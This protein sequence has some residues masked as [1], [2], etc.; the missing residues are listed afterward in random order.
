MKFHQLTTFITPASLPR[1][2][3]KFSFMKKIV[4]SRLNYIVRH[5]AMDFCFFRTLFA[6]SVQL[7]TCCG[8]KQQQVLISDKKV[9]YLPNNLID[10]CIILYIEMKE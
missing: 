7:K 2:N 4:K 3:I 1:N 8:D 9:K 5:R 6:S 10:Q